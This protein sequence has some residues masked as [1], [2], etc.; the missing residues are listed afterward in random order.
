MYASAR[1]LFF[2][3]FICI[4]AACSKGGSGT[5]DDGNG[6]QIGH[7]SGVVDTTAPNLTVNTPVENQVYNSGDNISVTGRITDDLGLYQGSIRI[8]NDANGAVLKE[9]LYEIHFILGYDFNVN[10]VATVTT[11]SNYTVTVSFM[12]HGLNIASKSVHVKVNP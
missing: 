4:L 6:G 3:A 7:D 5:V 11:L 12:D 2:V 10:Y 8:T 9:Q 1:Y